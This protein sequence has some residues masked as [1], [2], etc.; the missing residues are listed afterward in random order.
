MS[1]ERT[2][3]DLQD[4]FR[5]LAAAAPGAW[6]G[7]DAEAFVREVRGGDGWI[8]CDDR[9]PEIGERGVSGE[10]LAFAGGDGDGNYWIAMFNG[11][12]WFDRDYGEWIPNVTHWRPLPPGPG[13]GA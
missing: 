2:A 5:D 6:D 11:K 7:V 4:A 9:L 3:D 10:V 8:A 12:L 1:E 13:G